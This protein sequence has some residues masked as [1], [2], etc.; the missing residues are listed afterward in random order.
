ML[1]TD[2]MVDEAGRCIARD[3][4]IDPAD[5]PSFWSFLPWVA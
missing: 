1:Y 2:A 3:I 5:E 4:M